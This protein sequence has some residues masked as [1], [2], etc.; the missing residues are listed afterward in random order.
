MKA[1]IKEKQIS[2]DNEKPKFEIVDGVLKR[3][4]ENTEHIIVPDGVKI[5]GARAFQG[6]DRIQ[7]IRRQENQLRY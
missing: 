5:I 6:C 7:S 4:F 2:I 3:S 1:K